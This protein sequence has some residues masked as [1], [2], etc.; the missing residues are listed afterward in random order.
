MTELDAVPA[1]RERRERRL[2][3]LLVALEVRRQLPDDRPQLRCSD[4]RLYALVVTADPLFQVGEPLDVGEVAARLQ[5]EHEAGRCLLDP[6][7][8][9][10]LGGE[11]VE[12]R[13]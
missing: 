11:S 7:R 6:A 3:P 1:F 9:S 12:G 8:D 2:E 13:V 10:L 5:R 4:E